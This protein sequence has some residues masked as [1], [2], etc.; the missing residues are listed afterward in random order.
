MRS[1]ISSSASGT[2]VRH[3]APERI[4]RIKVP[5]PSLDIQRR[6]S[7]ILSTFDESIENNRRRIVLLE[8]AG[9]QLYVEWF[10]RLR[11]PGFEHAKVSNGVPN[12]WN[13]K[14]L[15]DIC[16]EVRESVLPE[17]VEPDTP[18]I[19]LEHMPRR[20]ISLAEWGFAEQVSSSKHRF[21]EGEILFGK[22]RPYFHKV[23]VP[24][25]DGIAS[26]EGRSD[27]PRDVI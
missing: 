19:G 11:F 3:T 15:G 14:T 2:K 25:V 20:S 26:S 1:E 6:I 22:I 17:S 13:D 27:E 21:R 18:Y 5:V 10:M 24:F 4:G 23:G 8:E 12:G 7:G 9:R 16:E